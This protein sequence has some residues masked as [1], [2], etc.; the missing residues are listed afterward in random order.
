MGIRTR[1]VVMLRK[2]RGNEVVGEKE[3]DLKKKRNDKQMPPFF[4]LR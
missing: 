1:W 2:D 4:D 3:S